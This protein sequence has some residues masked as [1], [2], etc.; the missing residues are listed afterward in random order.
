MTAK[1]ATLECPANYF[2]KGKDYILPDDPDT[3][4]EFERRWR[5]WE[6][7]HPS[8][9]TG[10]TALAQWEAEHGGTKSRSARVPAEIAG[11]DVEPGDSDDMATLKLELP[12]GHIDKLKRYA[13]FLRRRP[14]DVLMIWIER[15]CK[16]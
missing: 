11:G 9:P 10:D 6:A 3:V 4:A 12:T 2:G 7:E 13:R 16:L 15:H 14:R 8:D 1:T 5:E